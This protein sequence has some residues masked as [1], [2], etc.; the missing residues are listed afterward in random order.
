MDNLVFEFFSK[1]FSSYEDAIIFKE[2]IFNI[3]ENKV[4]KYGVLVIPGTKTGDALINIL[5]ECLGEYY[6][7]YDNSRNLKERLIRYDDEGM[8]ALTIIKGNLNLYHVYNWREDV[9]DII[10]TYKNNN[11]RYTICNINN[12]NTELVKQ[13]LESR[14]DGL[15]REAVINYLQINYLQIN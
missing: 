10:K 11:I 13:I 5:R 12:D 1:V 8:K 15:L 3:L 6:N 14:H 7:R 4:N 9:T 2:Y